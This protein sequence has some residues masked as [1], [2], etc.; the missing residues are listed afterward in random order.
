MISTVLI[1]EGCGNYT[2]IIV[3]TMQGI[4]V[5]S[6]LL[7]FLN[8]E[9]VGTDRYTVIERS[10]DYSNW[11]MVLKYAYFHIQVVGT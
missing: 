11:Q 3:S 2:G 10:G 1:W 7:A 8:T 5:A 6:V 9:H 4:I